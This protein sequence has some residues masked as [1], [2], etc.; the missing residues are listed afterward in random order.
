[1]STA[2]RPALKLLTN[3]LKLFVIEKED[4]LASQAVSLP[5]LEPSFRNCRQRATK[6]AYFFAAEKGRAPCAFGHAD[7]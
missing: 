3:C 1:M 5:P 4:F 6:N 2:F 7:K